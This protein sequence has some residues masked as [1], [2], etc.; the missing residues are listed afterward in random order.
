MKAVH[1]IHHITAI[2][3]DPRENY[4]FYTEVL[5][6]R[7]V[8]KSINQDVPDTYHLFFADGA[9][10]P[11]TD[12][13]FFPWPDM[14]PGRVGAGVWGEVSF[15]VPPGALDYWEPRLRSFG[16][17][18]GPREERF[19]EAV[20][21]FADPHG[22]VLSLSES[23]PWEG[24]PFAPWTNSP[25][26]AEYQIRALGSVRLTVRDVTATEAFLAGAFGFH[27]IDREGIWRRFGTGDGAAGQ[28]VDIAV[29]P[30]VPRGRWGVGAVH[31]VAFRIPDTDEQEVVRSQIVQEGGQPSP[32]I[33]RFW[34]SSVYVREPSGALCEVATDGPG[35]SVDE[36]PDHLGETLVLPPWYE[37]QRRQIEAILVPLETAGGGHDA[38]S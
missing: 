13:T 4:R 5:G 31:H 27:E 36:D 11:G 10:H 15:S 12:L 7:L 19:G 29:D 38:A 16:V 21:P 37:S 30:E 22:M 24:Q 35:F 6:L 23:V 32:V 3:G 18:V 25:V 2:A 14:G 8:K 1:G 9:G 28:R 26:P 34:F 20:L 33:D 17:A